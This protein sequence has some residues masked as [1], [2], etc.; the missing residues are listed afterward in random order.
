MSDAALARGPAVSGQDVWGWKVA[1]Y[2]FVSGMGAGV[3]AVGAGAERLGALDLARFA[4]PLGPLLVGPATLFLIG[5]LGRP[6]GFLRAGRRPGTSWISRGVVVLTAFLAASVL[7]AACALLDGPAAARLALSIA[8]GALALLTMAYTGLLLGAV[9]PIP[10]WTTP[11]LPLLF[12]V[13]SLSTGAMAADLVAAL[14]GRSGRVLAALRAADLALLAIEAGVL[15]LYLGLGHATV[16]SRAA[17]ALV[18]RGELASRFWGGVVAA[19]LAAPF[20][21]Q[22]GEVTG[23][24]PGGAWTLLSSACGLAGGLALR[25]V[26]VAGGVK[27]PLAA[28]GMLFTLPRHPRAWQA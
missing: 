12:V 20:A 26:V 10:F 4:L 15:A 28:A 2:L 6:G 8:G 3:Y 22:L 5:D 11:V 21:I 9:R 13:S 25:Q 16:A 19:G 1:V 24:L 18:V 14:A 7:H 17:T 27:S 23:A